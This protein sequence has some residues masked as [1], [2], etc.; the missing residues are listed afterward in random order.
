MT[1]HY[2]WGQNIPG[3]LPMSDEPNIADTFEDARAALLED[4]CAAVDHE[5]MGDEADNPG[6]L[7]SLLEAES[8][9]AS[10]TEPDT[11]YASSTRPHDLGLAFWIVACAEDDCIILPTC[12]DPDCTVWA[13]TPR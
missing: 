11:A 12:G 5:A 1:V 4:V 10:W 8:L 6:M 3:Y 7:A 9:I 2:H 13:H